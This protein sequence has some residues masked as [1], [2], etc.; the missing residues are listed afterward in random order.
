MIR[1]PGILKIAAILTLDFV[2][3]YSLL[4]DASIASVITGVIALYVWL[5]GY[6]SLHNEMAGN[7]PK[8]P[9][10]QKKSSGV[11][12]STACRRCQ[13]CECRQYFNPEAL[14]DSRKR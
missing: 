14:P 10:T 3:I 6:L 8:T 11:S 9:L 1:L 5:G 13:V 7:Q 2:A 4:G 12:Q